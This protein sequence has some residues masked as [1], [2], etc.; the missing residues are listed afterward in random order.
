MENFIQNLNN[1]NLGG[2]A[3]LVSFLP[4]IIAYI[5]VDEEKDTKKTTLKIFCLVA[6]LAFTMTVFGI[7]SALAGKIFMLNGANI[8]HFLQVHC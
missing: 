6:G 1:G 8:G 3:L 7:L 5:G 4:L 2:M